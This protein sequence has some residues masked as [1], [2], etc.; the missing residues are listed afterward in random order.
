MAETGQKFKN[1]A[2]NI[3]L[4]LTMMNVLILGSLKRNVPLERCGKTA[5]QMK[6]VA[7]L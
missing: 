7:I 2:Q 4:K 3:D 5:N 6:R 1:I